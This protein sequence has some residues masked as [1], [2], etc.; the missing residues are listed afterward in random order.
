MTDPAIERVD[1]TRRVVAL[2]RPWGPTVPTVTVIAVDVIDSDGAS[3]HGFTW[4]PTIGGPAIEAMIHHDLV[5]WARGRPAL[6]AIWSA[7]WEHLHEAGGGGVTTLALAGLDLALWDLAGR[8]AGLGLDDLLG[9]RHESQPAYASGVNLHYPHTELMAQAARWQRAGFTAAKIKVGRE[10]IADDVARVTAVREILGPDARIMVDANQRWDID[11]ATRA[12]ERL[13]GLGIS[14]LEE[15]LRSDDTAGYVELRRRTDVPIALGE[16]VHHIHRFRD[17]I[18]AGACD[19]VQP[20]V[21][22][23]GGVTPFL[24]IVELARDRGT[25]LGPHLLVDLSAR[26]AATLP[27]TTWVEVVEDSDFGRLGVLARPSGVTIDRG[28]AFVAPTVGLGVEID[29]EHASPR[30]REGDSP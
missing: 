8:R 13:A 26:L 6:P 4:T 3:G 29:H 28:R 16:N 20:N 21:V 7:A 19:V 17:L 5:P 27:E 11:T 30:R 1:V 18:D 9:R 14:W 15:P 12:A 23:V 22:R 25:P 2:P 10:A 24:A